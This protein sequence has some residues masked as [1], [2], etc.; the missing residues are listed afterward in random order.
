[1]DKVTEVPTNAFPA[2]VS[3]DKTIVAFAHTSVVSTTSVMAHAPG[4]PVIH[5]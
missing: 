3:V 4:P 5:P 1:M 2:V